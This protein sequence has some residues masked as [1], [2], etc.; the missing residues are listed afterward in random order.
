MK[1]LDKIPTNQIETPPWPDDVSELVAGNTYEKEIRLDD[2]SRTK[3]EATVKQVIEGEG[4]RLPEG[5][6]VVVSEQASSGGGN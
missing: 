2:G 3:V 5:A 4:T 6:K 1:N